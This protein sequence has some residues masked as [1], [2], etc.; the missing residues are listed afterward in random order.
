MIAIPTSVEIL[1][2]EGLPEPYGREF[3]IMPLSQGE[4]YVSQKGITD[5]FRYYYDRES[6]ENTG[7]LAVYNFLATKIDKYRNQA[8]NLGR[9]LSEQNSFPREHRALAVASIMV[10][11]EARRIGWPKKRDLSE[12]Q[13]L[14]YH[15]AM[16]LSPEAF[17]MARGQASSIA[18]ENCHYWVDA[19]TKS[20]TDEIAIRLQEA[21]EESDH[22]PVEV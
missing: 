14:K 4:T 17:G 19:I 11:Q 18:I 1:L 6:D 16:E 12:M 13:K 8:A 7:L 22:Y 9:A 3:V 20:R 15:Q 5:R 10:A 2:G 21:V